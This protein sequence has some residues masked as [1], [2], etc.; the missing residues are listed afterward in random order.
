LVRF[1]VKGGLISSTFVCFTEDVFLAEDL[2]EV[3]I[4]RPIFVAV[5][6]E[7]LTEG[8]LE[9]VLAHVSAK[10]VPNP[11]CFQVVQQGEPV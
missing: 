8:Q 3:P 1:E 2:L 9:N 7:E 5:P 11:C 6:S 4:A 10:K